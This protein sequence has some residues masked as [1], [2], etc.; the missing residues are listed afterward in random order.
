[1]KFAARQ[2]RHFI[3]FLIFI[4]VCYCNCRQLRHAF[5]EVFFRHFTFCDSVD[6]IQPFLGIN[7]VKLV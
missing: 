2:L 1:M 7:K 3:I 5:L 6:F 4:Y